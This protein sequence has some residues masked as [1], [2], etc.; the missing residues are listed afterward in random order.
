[1]PLVSIGHS[2]HSLQ[3]VLDL[4][5]AAD[6]TAVADVRSQPYSRRVPQF[7][8]NTLRDD[9]KAAGLAYVPM[10]DT[11]GGRTTDPRL[12]TDN[13]P[14]YEKMARVPAF[15]A[16][17]RR[18]LDG[19]SRYTV[20]ILC[21]ER[22]PLECHRCRLVGRALLKAGA[23]I[24]HILP[25]GDRTSQSTIENQLLAALGPDDLFTEKTDRLALAYR[26]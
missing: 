19:A 16:G 2:N 25:D 1:M 12:L 14:D 22:H 24:Q 21:R 5:T 20:A 26:T 17:I 18:L 3:Q 15:Q 23:D 6:V 9:L 4:L 8:A 7:N 13:V 10:G 11:L